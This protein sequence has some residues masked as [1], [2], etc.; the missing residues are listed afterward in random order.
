MGKKKRVPA[1]II[2]IRQSFVVLLDRKRP[3][4]IRGVSTKDE[5]RELVQTMIDTGEY[6]MRAG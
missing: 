1:K 2:T 6:D 4:I 3:V 5:A